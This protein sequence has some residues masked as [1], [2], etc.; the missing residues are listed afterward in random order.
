MHW[1][2]CFSDWRGS[3]QG[4]KDPRGFLFLIAKCGSAQR[5]ISE[6]VQ[7][8]VLLTHVQ[9]H[10]SNFSI[11]HP[12]LLLQQLSRS[13][14]S[15]K[16]VC[17]VTKTRGQINATCSSSLRGEG[18]SFWMTALGKDRGSF[19]DLIRGML[20]ADTW[21]SVG[22]LTKTLQTPLGRNHIAKKST[23]LFITNSMALA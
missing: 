22:E 3:K 10:T 5:F 20:E 13:R 11:K 19:N 1:S 14:L 23:V 6:L 2:C 17:W 8:P 12:S 18:I 16:G 21:I 9:L 4:H 7:W 15:Q